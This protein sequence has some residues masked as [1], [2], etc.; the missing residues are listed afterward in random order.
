LTRF[1][2]EEGSNNY[3]EWHNPQYNRLL[4]EASV[5]PDPQ[6]RMKVLGEAEQLLIEEVPVIPIYFG[7]NAYMRAPQLKNVLITPIGNI[8]FRYAY[9]TSD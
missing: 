5:T 1:S 7:N 9:F 2:N 3:A 4:E 8:D 6:K